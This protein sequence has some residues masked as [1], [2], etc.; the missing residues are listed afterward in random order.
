MIKTTLFVSCVAAAAS[1]VEIKLETCASALS[2]I[3]TTTSAEG[4]GAGGAKK[5]A[6]TASSADAGPT[7]GEKEAAEE[8]LHEMTEE[9]MNADISPKK[10]DLI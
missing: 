5:K 6:A 9:M 2:Q 3:M 4:S 7:E 8:R 1:A 10:A